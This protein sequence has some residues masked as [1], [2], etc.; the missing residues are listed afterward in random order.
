MFFQHR[1]IRDFDDFDAVAAKSFG[2]LA[3]LFEAPVFVEA[4]F[5]NRLFEAFVFDDGIISAQGARAES[6][7]AGGRQRGGVL[8]S[9]AA[10]T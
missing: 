3:H 2:L 9:A 10:S 7:S 8:Q 5:D 4:P 1:E 6:Q